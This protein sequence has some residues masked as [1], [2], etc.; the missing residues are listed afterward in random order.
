MNKLLQPVIWIV[1]TSAGMVGEHLK[2]AKLYILIIPRSGKHQSARRKTSIR[3]KENTNPRKERS[4]S[5]KERTSCI[6]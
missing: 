6:M 5:P 1:D 4:N 2:I 3:G